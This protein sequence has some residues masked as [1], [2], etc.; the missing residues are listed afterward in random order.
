[1]CNLKNRINQPT[2]YKNADNPS[3][4]D[5]M[6]TNDKGSFQ[7]SLAIETGLSDHHKMT[8]SVLKRYIKK[9]APTIVKYRNYIN[10]SVKQI[11]EMI[12]FGNLK[13]YIMES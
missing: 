7:N 10:I 2:C 1:M 4:F 13:T 8:I 6:L 5:V 3:S 11:L 9:R 12:L